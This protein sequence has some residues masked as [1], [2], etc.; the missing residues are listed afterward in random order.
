M[1]NKKKMQAIRSGFE[2]E[3]FLDDPQ[4]LLTGS[5]IP[6]KR[7]YGPA[8]ISD[9][10]YFND[11][12]L[13]GAP[14]FT[15]GAYPE[16]YRK[17]VWTHRQVC[18][19]GTAEET[20]ERLRLLNQMGQTGLNIVPDT[21]TIYGLDSDNPLAEGEVGREGVAIDSLEDMRDMLEG[22]PLEEDR[23]VQF[24]DIP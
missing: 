1:F 17:Q 10:D 5:G 23:L 20:N 21:P 13:P 8:D 4:A 7:L 6:I 12:G 19:Y 11:L 3:G 24:L 14:P 9:L 2:K 15:R 22:I 18:G 16:M